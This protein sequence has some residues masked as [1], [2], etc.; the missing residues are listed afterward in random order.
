M[1]IT[2]DE[3]LQAVWRAVANHLPYA[4]T[5]NYFGNKRGLVP[6][7]EFYMRYST[8]ICT[9]FRA[10][11]LLLPIGNSA[12]MK[13]IQ[14]LIKQGRLGAERHRFGGAFHFWLPDSLNKPAFEETLRLL[15]LNGVTKEPVDASAFDAIAYSITA[16]LLE[17]F[18]DKP[19]ETVLI[20]ANTPA[21]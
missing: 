14:K 7:D 9:A 19:V 10:N 21:R 6:N 20:P 18:G 2:D 4:A 15:E 17:R 12:S 1:K 16:S 8:H 11:R 5:H 3:F 13:K